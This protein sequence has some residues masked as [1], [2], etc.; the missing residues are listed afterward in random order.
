M[1]IIFSRKGMDGSSVSGKF[2]FA[3]PIIKNQLIWLPIPADEKREGKGVSYDKLRHAAGIGTFV[4]EITGHRIKEYRLSKERLCH[5]DPDIRWDIIER[6]GCKWKAGFGQDGSAQGLLEKPETSVKSGDLFL[7]YGWFRRAVKINSRWKYA[8]RRNEDGYDRHVIW[9]WLQVD[10]PHKLKDGKLPEEL[11]NHPHAD[12][13]Y[14]DNHDENN[15][16][17]SAR[18]KLTISGIMT[19]DLPG[20]GIFKEYKPSLCLTKNGGKDG[21]RSIWKLDGWNKSK[22]DKPL[23][24][25][26][27]YDASRWLDDKVNEN[28]LFLETVSP[29]QEFVLN[30]DD[31]DKKVPKADIIQ[32]LR[33]IFN[34]NADNIYPSRGTY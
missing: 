19:R 2:G 33:N 24:L 15:T 4:E 18:N 22:P 20:A 29:G 7:F 11:I 32:W 17:Y 12:R 34:D 23:P 13:K 5:L 6:N 28:D 8:R 30:L 26:H 21:A 10:E 16:I 25:S 9:G 3:S 27:H 14:K 31:K 1:K